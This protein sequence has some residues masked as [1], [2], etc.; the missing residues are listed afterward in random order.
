MKI[1]KLFALLLSAVILST[2]AAGCG[3]DSA[4]E[5]SAGGSSSSTAAST[6]S[7]GEESAEE[8]PVEIR[9]TRPLY[10]GDA[11]EN[12]DLKE[13][14]M[15]MVEE[16]YGVKVSVNY[17]PRNEYTSKV[18]LLMTSD[19]VD[20][21]VGVFG[22]SEILNYK[23]MGVIVPFDE[24][25]ADNE[26]WNSMP[27]AMQELY[28]FDGEMWGL[29]AGF[30]TNLF[31]RTIR[32]DWLDNLG[33]EAPTNVDEL[34]DMAYAFTYDDPDGNGVDDTY[35]L[36]ASGTWNLQD[37]FQAFD[38]RLVNGGG[39]SIVYDPAE[40]CWIDSMLKPGMVECLTYLNKMYEEGLLD[41]E[42]F[43][44]SG[45]N[46]REKFWAGEY[47][48]TFYWLG[49]SGESAPYLTKITPDVEFV[50]VPYLTGTLTEETNCMWYGSV[51]YIMVA[52]TPDADKMAQEFVNLALGSQE[53][54]FDF[55][56]GIEGKTYRVEDQTVYTL[57]DPATDTPMTTPSLT[58]SIP[59]YYDDWT[60]LT[61]GL[62]AEAEQTAI[63]LLNF[64]KSVIQDGLDAGGIYEL[65]EVITTPVSDTYL[66]IQEDI[67]IAF[68][69]A[70]SSAV[71][72][73][74]DP[75]TAVDTYL[76]EVKA[77][78]AQDVLDEANE[79][80]G[81]TGTLSY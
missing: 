78:G 76:A 1:K 26:T 12:L 69:T 56:Y 71:T 43:T 24:Y 39:S 64:K 40:N 77:L 29:P 80:A 68:D 37:I 14:W 7:G 2:M 4:E 36:T 59:K 23:D 27:E 81:L 25:L 30:T 32:K 8:E 45:S 41:P 63:D 57:V 58:T 74:V 44:N 17:L 20:G 10:F 46:M 61:D 72:G 51:P 42:L 11:S 65:S 21:L 75:Q 5:S 53:S 79:A 47:G 60:F 16:K 34:Y 33:M 48:S 38:A 55:A 31:T 3:N 62:D 22:S 15:Q 13:E 73:T 9:I 67:S 54:H 18:N 70:V 50:E 28:V 35:G 19:S 66:M 6:S 52:D 49:F